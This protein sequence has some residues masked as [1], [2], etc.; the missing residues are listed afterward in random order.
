VQARKRNKKIYVYNN[1]HS[2]RSKKTGNRQKKHRINEIYEYIYKYI[3]ARILIF[4]LFLCVCICSSSNLNNITSRLKN[5]HNHH[6]HQEKY[7]NS[8]N[9]M[10]SPVDN[11]K[12]STIIGLVFFKRKETD[13]LLERHM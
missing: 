12:S 8:R 4:F 13:T 2:R 7:K 6:Y 10:R 3:R 9:S 5:Q 1:I 11:S